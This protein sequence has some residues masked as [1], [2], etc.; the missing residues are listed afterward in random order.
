MTADFEM[1]QINHTSNE[2][3]WF[4]ESRSSKTSPKRDWYI[5]RPATYDSVGVRHPPCNW[6]AAFG[7]SVWEWDEATEEYYLHYWVPEQP[8]DY[9]TV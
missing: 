1:L 2:H 4:Q 7:G 8:G 5:W 3:P 6:R 9:L